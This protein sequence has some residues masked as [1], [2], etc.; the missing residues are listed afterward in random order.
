MSQIKDLEQPRQALK[1]LTA[2][3]NEVLSDSNQGFQFTPNF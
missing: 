1:T 2:V 3:M